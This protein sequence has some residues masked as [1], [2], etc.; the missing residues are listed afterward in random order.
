MPFLVEININ[1]AYG[2]QGGWN[3]GDLLLMWA[4]AL[5]YLVECSKSPANQSQSINGMEADCWE[6]NAVPG[7]GATQTWHGGSGLWQYQMTGQ[8]QD[9]L[10][11][12]AGLVSLGSSGDNTVGVA[13]WAL[14]NA[15]G[16]ADALSYLGT[17]Y[18]N[19]AFSQAPPGTNTPPP[20]FW[21]N[22]PYVYGTNS[23]AG[24]TYQPPIVFDPSAF[25]TYSYLF[26]PYNSATRDKGGIFRFA[27]GV[28][29]GSMPPWS[30]DSGFFSDGG[31]P[32]GQ[33][34]D[35]QQMMLIISA[36]GQGGTM[37]FNIDWVRV[38]Q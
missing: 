29:T 1:W 6:I 21:T 4:E 37:T 27:D 19:G 16:N 33:T 35:W 2:S 30:P 9:G 11:G 8:G 23:S 34:V 20:N 31:A 14:N 15:W 26:L 3:A 7:G 36:G 17:F 13:P 18:Y 22:T 32:Y 28:F 38:T 25:H 10:I 12:P 24:G 5:E